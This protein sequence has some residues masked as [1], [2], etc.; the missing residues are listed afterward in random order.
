MMLQ[1]LYAQNLSKLFTRVTELENKI[2]SLSSISSSSSSPETITKDEFDR[3][4]VDV[5]RRLSAIDT[6]FIQKEKEKERERER[7]REK[8]KERER[9]REREKEKEKKGFENALIVKTDAQLSKK[10]NQKMNELK[11]WFENELKALELQFANN[12]YTCISSPISPSPCCNSDCVVN[13]QIEEKKKV[14]LVEIVEKE[15]EQEI[16]RY[17]SASIR[18]TPN[19]PFLVASRQD[20]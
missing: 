17:S 2:A 13:K 5:S 9:E 16:D 14:E 12:V 4:Q 20:F 1:E 18:I 3:F 8:E 10:I 15:Q 11:S 19:E 7:E 6:V